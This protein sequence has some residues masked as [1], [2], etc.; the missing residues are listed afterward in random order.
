MR[1][2]EA[3]I[4]QLQA[5][6]AYPPPVQAARLAE[7]KTLNTQAQELEQK[8]A[9]SDPR[10]GQLVTTEVSLKTLQAKLKPGEVFVKVVL[11]DQGGFAVAVGP[12]WAKP[13]R[14]ALDQGSAEDAVTALRRPFETENRL[15]AYDVGASYKFFEAVF[16]PVQDQ[17][18]KADHIIYEPDPSILSLP[19]SAL[20]TD[21]KSVALIAARRAS[22]RAKGEGVLS[23][24]GVDWLGKSAETSLVV[25]AAS[26][27]QARDVPPSPAPKPFLGFGDSLK[28]QASDPRAFASV[29]N[30]GGPDS[31]LIDDQVCRATR[32]AL[33]TLKP[34]KEASDELSSVGASL[35]AGPGSDVT[36]AAFNDA[37][38]AMRDDLNQY[39]VVYFATHG[40]L[41]RPGGCLPE[42]LAPDLGRRSTGRKRRA[43]DREQDPGSQAQRRSGGAVGLRHGRRRQGRDGSHGSRRRGR[44]AGRADPRLHLRRRAQPAGLALAD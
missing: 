34:L 24:N 40:L 36:G 30:R 43:S 26:F 11:L 19:I 37:Q 25:S 13:Y 22:I 31:S 14:I 6:N 4:A 32:E 5:Q 29:V 10:Y 28:P 16:G 2:K 9:A 3:E 17:L 7:L 12:D 44:V 15:P 23:Y 33:L 39:R 42:T 8:V 41:P 38:I 27:V 20:A 21:P 35:G 18:L 1:L